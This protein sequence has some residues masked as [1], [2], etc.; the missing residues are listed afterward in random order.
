MLNSR[1]PIKILYTFVF[2]LGVINFAGC[3]KCQELSDLICDCQPDV[4]SVDACRKT[5]SLRTS[6]KGFVWVYND[7]VCEE[8]INRKGSEDS[9]CNCQAI[10]RQEYEK[11]GM[12]RQDKP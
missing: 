6:N 1:L 5:A 12:T 11:C 2:L 3:S 10:I 8:V 4:Q 9:L 7:A